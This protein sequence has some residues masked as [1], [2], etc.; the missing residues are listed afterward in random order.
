MLNFRLQQTCYACP[1]QYD[2]YMG[3]QNVAYLRLRHGHFY[4]QV[5][6]GG[7]VV[8]EADTKGDGVFDDD[9]RSFHLGNAIR[10]ILEELKVEIDE[11][12][13]RAIGDPDDWEPWTGKP[14]VG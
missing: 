13:D 5:P 14:R 8:Y 11:E 6:F 1:E 10:A 9:E 7:K 3:D 12:Y 2:F 4:A